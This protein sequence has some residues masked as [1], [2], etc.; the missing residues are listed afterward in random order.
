MKSLFFLACFA[1][2][3]S[4]ASA[5]D[6]PEPRTITSLA[7][8]AT[9]TTQSGQNIKM[10]PGLY[11]LVDL[12]PLSSIKERQKRKEWQ[13]FHFSGS[14]NRFDLTGVTIELDTALRQALNSPIHTDEF[15]ISGGNVEVKGLTITSVGNGTAYAGAVLGVVGRGTTLRNC[16]IHV[17]GSSPYGYGDLFG[18]G[19]RKHSGVHITGSN[20]RLLGC[21]VFTKAYGH[22]FYMQE[23]CNDLYFEN[24][25]AEGVMRSTTEM[26]KETNSFAT[27]KNFQTE[28]KTHAGDFQILPGY[29]KALSEDGFRTYGQ[30]KNLVL[31]NCTAKNM[32]G[33]FELRTKTAPR[34]EGCI[35]TGCERAFW[36]STGAVV[37]RC[38]GDAQYGPLLF[39]E[40]DDATVEVELLPSK[41]TDAKVHELAAIYGKGNKVVIQGSAGKQAREVPILLGYTPP[42]MGTALSPVGVRDA[43]NVSLRNETM[44]PVIIGAKAQKC[45]VR[46]AGPVKENK[47]KENVVG[48]LE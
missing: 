45:E 22:A 39:V 35:A 7:E 32:R 21:K 10:K 42:A 27:R 31:K 26:L 41:P 33:G 2:S 28:V 48:G 38:K 47:G 6:K 20:T 34:L 8:L 24:C 25:H 40:G 4:S 14:D 11:R 13:F 23:D 30:H 37:S 18:K 29:M 15:L 44:M 16:T 19:G 36:V 5:A 9:A 17:Q 12:I 1:A 43:R 46:S 3:I